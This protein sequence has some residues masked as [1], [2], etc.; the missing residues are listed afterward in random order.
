[1]VHRKGQSSRQDALA[2]LVAFHRSMWRFYRLHYLRGWN[3]LW[4]PLVALAI[5]ARLGCLLLLNTLRRNPI[6][7][8]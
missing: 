3:A 4:S 1:V 7:S 6:V 2:M 8:P 5:I